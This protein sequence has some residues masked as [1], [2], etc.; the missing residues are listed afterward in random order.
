MYELERSVFC[1][2]AATADCRALYPVPQGTKRE[3]NSHSEYHFFFYTLEIIKVRREHEMRH[4]LAPPENVEN[5]CFAVTNL[6]KI[7]THCERLSKKVRER[8]KTASGANNTQN[9]PFEKL[10]PVKKCVT[11]LMFF[12]DGFF[13]SPFEQTSCSAVLC[14]SLFT[15]KTSLCS[16]GQQIVPGFIFFII[17]F[18]LERSRRVNDTF[19]G[20]F[21]CLFF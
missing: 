18:Y 7:C 4:A 9:A 10:H 17:C 12:C 6:F 15:S 1:Y 21:V 8:T 11:L 3:E 19:K 5:N 16:L 13:L 2:R 14:A 20:M